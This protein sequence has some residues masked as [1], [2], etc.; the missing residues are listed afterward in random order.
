[1]RALY[2]THQKCLKRGVFRSLQELKY[3]IHCFLDDTNAHPKPF[4]IGEGLARVD[5][6]G[7]TSCP[8]RAGWCS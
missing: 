7:S 8:P 6:C 1:M 2:E 4:T 3:A 5:V